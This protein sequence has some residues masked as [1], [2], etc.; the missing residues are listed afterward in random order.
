MVLEPGVCVRRKGSGVARELLDG[1][2]AELIVVDPYSGERRAV[3]ASDK[4]LFEAPNWSPDGHWLLVNADGGLFRVAADA[5]AAGDLEPVD[6][7][8]VPPINN[9]HV[10]SP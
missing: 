1:Q 2:R 5:P 6:L 3:H 9:D 7:G 10:L 4:T 8:G